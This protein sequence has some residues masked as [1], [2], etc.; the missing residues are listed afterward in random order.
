MYCTLFIDKTQ[1]I[2][3]VMYQCVCACVCACV[4]MRACM[5]ICVRIYEIEISKISD[6]YTSTDMFYEF[7]WLC[8]WLWCEHLRVMWDA[9]L[10][11]AK[12]CIRTTL[13]WTLDIWEHQSYEQKRLEA[14]RDCQCITHKSL[15]NTLICTDSGYMCG[16]TDIQYS[17]NKCASGGPHSILL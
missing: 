1:M 6:V 12:Y 8:V 13:V 17:P 3:S 2:R 16:Q 14:I 4:C 5:W 15:L 11:L 9:W 7:R 10:F